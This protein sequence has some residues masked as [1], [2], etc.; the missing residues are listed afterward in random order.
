LYKDLRQIFMNIIYILFGKFRTRITLAFMSAM[1]A[2][3]AASGIFLYHYISDFVFQGLRD[4]LIELAEIA[5]VRIDPEMLS[6]IPLN[7]KGADSIPYKRIEED[8][9]RM[10]KAA[11]SIKYIYIFKKDDVSS[12]IL[13][14]VVDVDTQ[15][16]DEQSSAQPGDEYDASRYPELIEGFDRPSADR[17][18]TQDK[19]GAFLSGYAPIRDR[20]GEPIAVLGVDMDAE[21]V[22]KIQSDIKRFMALGLVFGISLSFFLAIFASGGISKKVKALERG[23]QR[24][25][26]GDLDYN[27]K[28][29]GDDELTGLAVFFN[30]MSIDL[31][32]YIEELK[33]TTSEKERM[34]S[35]LNIAKKI[36]QSFLPDSAPVMPG[37]D[38]AAMTAPARVVG[39]DFYDFIP[40]DKNK[41]GIVIADV[42]G[43][44]V[45]A[46]LFVA[47]SRAIIRSNASLFG[48]PDMMIKNA[49]SK[50]IEL[51]SSNMFETL[52]YAVLD[53]D[54]MTFS[55]ANAG[56]NP[57]F[58]WSTSN[59]EIALFKAQTFP[60]GIK[61]D[62]QINT[63]VQSFRKGDTIMFYTD[64]V[65]EAMNEKREEYGTERLTRILQQNTSRSSSGIVDRIKEDIKLFTGSAEQHDDMTMVVVK[66][67]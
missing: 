55:Y 63:K 44:G 7:P 61:Q 58:I 43:K 51:S 28:V 31:K 67:V 12:S 45:P 62:M 3:C 6:S 8:L 47:L 17:A 23:F 52:F 39:G 2:V 29:E 13:R 14:F 59:G 53:A 57:P 22:Y 15:E 66:A 1:I 10:H 20:K 27:V 42:S 37:V 56:H 30:K 4:N 9:R 26:A 40:I 34:L 38:I 19:W 33:K 64:G 60:I 46:A 36:Q 24:V 18:I 41:W 21:D 16:K 54:K 5:S 49:N 11:P 25:S 65:T 50:I 35:E 48:L 32:Q